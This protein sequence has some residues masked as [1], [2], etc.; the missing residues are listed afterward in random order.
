MRGD[1][2]AIKDV[3]RGLAVLATAPDAG[4]DVE[5]AEFSEIYNSGVRS[6]SN[7]TSGLVTLETNLGIH[8][9]TLN[10]ADERNQ[11]ETLTLS[12]AFQ[13]LT[14]RDQFEAAAEL[15]QLEVQLEGSFILSSR[16]SQLSLTN[17]LR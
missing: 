14:G 7:G 3:L 10:K 11:F 13:A 16:L 8:A 1:D 9:E 12:T 4:F 2:A 17:F 15:N 5:S 6:T